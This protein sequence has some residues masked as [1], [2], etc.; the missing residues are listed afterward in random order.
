[1]EIKI[2]QSLVDLNKLFNQNGS[3]LYLVGGFVRNA[4][5]GFCETDMDITSSM[6]AEDVIKMLKNT[7]F[8]AHIVN[9]K[10]GTVLIKS[11][12]SE[13]EFEHTT[14]RAESYDLGGK[15]SPVD[16][17]FVDDI[18]LDASRRDFSA[19]CIYLNL[20]TN[21]IVDFY[22]GVEDV[23]SHVLRTVE[24]PEYVFSR[25]GLRI[26]RLVRMACELDFSIDDE[27]FS[28]AKNLVKQLDD[29][30][31]ER[32][33]KEIVSIL[34]SDYKYDAI[35]NPFSPT[36]GLKLL[37]E[38]GAWGYILPKF[39]SVVG[40]DKI[41]NDL[42]GDWCKTVGKV[43]PLHRIT[44]FCYDIL[45]ATKQP[46]TA[47]NINAI[48]GQGGVM[49]KKDEVKLQ[50]NLLCAYTKALVGFKSQDEKRLFIQ[51]NS[52]IFVRLIDFSKFL[53]N[54]LDD[55]ATEFEHMKID[56][57]PIS[58]KDLAVNGVD[59]GTHF[60]DIKKQ[61]YSKILNGLLARCCAL[62]ELNTKEQLLDFIRKGKF[63]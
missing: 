49:L 38:L 42:K 11:P 32:F 51:Q 36:R 60:P 28:V 57:V 61:H 37:S 39:T 14:F 34:F 23:N 12:L 27:C 9:P 19:N 29:I 17:K 6:L 15:H 4:I 58:L 18:K 45:T 16:V 25:D 35:K 13:D 52:D 21:E 41:T 43:A 1:M 55:L 62:P 20:S 8:K 26:L 40:F 46:Y 31:Q 5:L 44:A 47:A 33:N 10:L 56:K 3:Q 2:P 48:L 63:Q 50:A 22:G 53:G 7:Q 30:S 24:T 54:Q 59:I